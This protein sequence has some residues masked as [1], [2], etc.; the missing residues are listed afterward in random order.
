MRMER[1]SGTGGILFVVPRSAF[2]V[3]SSSISVVCIAC[4]LFALTKLSK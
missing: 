2:L 4:M 1:G 3:G